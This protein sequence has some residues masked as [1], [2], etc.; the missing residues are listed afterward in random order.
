MIKIDISNGR[1][2][3]VHQDKATQSIKV[4]TGKGNNIDSNVNIPEGDF[5]MLLNYYRYIK[6]YNIKCDFINPH[7]INTLE[8][9]PDTL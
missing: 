9:N 5:V 1:E 6:D 4:L 8:N 2:M 3:E 7:G